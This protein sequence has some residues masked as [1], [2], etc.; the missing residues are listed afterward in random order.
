[1][2]A[3]SPRPLQRHGRENPAVRDAA[4]SPPRLT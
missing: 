3:H 2:R 1:L 4:L